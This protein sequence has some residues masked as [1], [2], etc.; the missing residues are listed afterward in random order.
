MPD[1]RDLKFMIE[2]F[3][4]SKN[5]EDKEELLNFVRSTYKGA[6][7]CKE[8][9]EINQ[10]ID[11]CRFIC[12]TKKGKAYAIDVEDDVSTDDSGVVRGKRRFLSRLTPRK[13]TE[14]SKII[15]DERPK[16]YIEV[17]EVLPKPE[18]GKTQEQVDAEFEQKLQ[19]WGGKSGL[20]KSLQQ[21]VDHWWA[22]GM[23]DVTVFDLVKRSLIDGDAF[24]NAFWDAALNYGDG[25]VTLSNLEPK[26]YIPEPGVIGF[27]NLEYEFYDRRL[28]PKRSLREYGDIVY[29]I[30]GG[31]TSDIEEDKRLD[32]GS[33]GSTDLIIHDSIWNDSTTTKVTID[34]VKEEYP[35]YPHG[36]LI[37]WC[38]NTIIRDVANPNPFRPWEK[39]TL[40]SDPYSFWGQS[41]AIFISPFQETLDKI[42]QLIEENFFRTGQQ[43]IYF[44]SGAFVDENVMNDEPAQYVEIDANKDPK[45]VVFSHPPT[46]IAGDAYQLIEI[47][48]RMADDVSNVHPAAEGQQVGSNPSGRMIQS[49]QEASNLFMRQPAR[50]LENVMQRIMKKVVWLIYK[51]YKRGRKYTYTEDNKTRFAELPF[52]F[53]DFDMV[54]NITVER[55]SSLPKNKEAKA[56]MAMSL[57][58]MNSQ[59]WGVDFVNKQLELENEMPQET[60]TEQFEQLKQKVMLEI[61]SAGGNPQV[62]MQ[63]VQSGE[64]PP[65]LMNLILSELEQP[66]QPPQAGQ[67][68]QR[69]N[70]QI[71]QGQG[72]PPIPAAQPPGFQRPAAP[73]P[74]QQ[75]G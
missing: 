60:I 21:C 13:I 6:L 14:T 12:T 44:K 51:N 68:P 67:Q 26:N 53:E 19:A 70:E 46:V 10:W 27:D 23:I 31:F 52:D 35:V 74:L 62:I 22:S 48:E 5:A 64:V 9:L 41:L 45:D 17:A 66:G 34:G 37:S 11:Y 3:P 40:L 50:V 47:C 59:A 42:V 54:F 58:Q 39:L 24:P 36:R 61:Q 57:Y 2:Q 25:E 33:I 28:D 65:G 18:E 75:G 29:D 16:V 1:I 49:L 69:P 71:N 15:T 38:G 72:G 4:V 73:Q 32:R 30:E 55:G 7:D 63:L 8:R 43:K 56:N 20:R